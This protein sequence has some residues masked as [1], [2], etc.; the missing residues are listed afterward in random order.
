MRACSSAWGHHLYLSILSS[1]YNIWCYTYV[2]SACNWSCL[3]FWWIFR[4]DIIEFNVI[5]YCDKCRLAFGEDG[6]EYGHCSCAWDQYLCHHMACVLIH[7]M[8]NVSCTDED[9]VWKKWKQP[10]KVGKLILTVFHV[11]CQSLKWKKNWEKLLTS[12]KLLLML[13]MS[14]MQ[15]WDQLLDQC[16]L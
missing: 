7:A 4:F 16:S 12:I 1:E 13:C 8:F 10:K 9:F 14:W 6:I 5:F 2:C 15:V 3:G 11:E